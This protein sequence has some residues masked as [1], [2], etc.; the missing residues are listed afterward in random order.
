MEGD[1]TNLPWGDNTSCTYWGPGDIHY[2]GQELDG[3]IWLTHFP[4]RN[5]AGG[6]GRWMTTD[7]AGLA[8]VDPS[9]PQ[10]WN[11]YA[12]VADNPTNFVDPLGLACWPFERARFANCS[13][14]M[15]NGV[16]FGANWNQFDLMSIPVTVTTYTPAQPIDTPID[17]IYNQYGYAVEATIFIPAGWSNTQI[18][19]GFDLFGGSAPFA[20]GVLPPGMNGRFQ[21][22]KWAAQNFGKTLKPGNPSTIPA[23][24]EAPPEWPGDFQSELTKLAQEALQVIAEAAAD[25]TEF[26]VV[27][28]PTACIDSML[29]YQ[30]PSCNPGQNP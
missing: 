17:S 6:T 23:P 10:T 9:N 11:R 5:Y 2:T 20:A 25:A 13:P 3:G 22:S 26:F 16:Y 12:Y 29:N 30:L 7:P 19:T 14:F 15:N 27:V 28:S 24:P 18:G 4:M 8:A 1:C 21:F